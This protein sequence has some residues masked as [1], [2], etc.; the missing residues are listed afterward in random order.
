V[1]IKKLI[2]NQETLTEM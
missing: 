1:G 2:G